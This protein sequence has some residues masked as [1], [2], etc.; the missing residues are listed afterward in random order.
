M[1]KE[2]VRKLLI[3]IITFIMFFTT[4]TFFIIVINTLVADMVEEYNFFIR[5]L[6]EMGYVILS[7]I[8]ACLI[9]EKFIN[10]RD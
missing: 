9:T 10:T 1:N 5:T 4:F 3:Y 6:F 8:A 2:I 7:A